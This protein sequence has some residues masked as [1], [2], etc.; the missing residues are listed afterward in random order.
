[1][2]QRPTV[3]PSASRL[4]DMHPAIQATL[5]CM[6]VQLEDELARYRRAQRRSP[7]R[8]QPTATAGTVAGV[9]GGAAALAIASTLPLPDAPATAAQPP[10]PGFVPPAPA[11]DS[12][13]YMESSEHL[14][15]SLAEDEA[16]LRQEP[17]PRM[18]DTLLTPLGI[19]SMIL[20]LLSSVTLGYVLTNPA[21]LSFMGTQAEAPED[22]SLMLEGSE[23]TTADSGTAA[24]G[25]TA[26]GNSSFSP[27]LSSQEFRSLTLDTLSTLPED[28]PIPETPVTATGT[29][30]QST[31]PGNTAAQPGSGASTLP[32]TPA[33]SSRSAAAPPARSAAAPAPR[34][35]PAPAPAPAPR[36]QAAAPAPRP[37]PAPAPAPAPSRSPAPVAAAPAAAS[38]SYFYVITDYTG[39]RALETAQSAMGD[40]YVRNFDMGAVIQF[41]AF[42]E[43]DRAESLIQDLQRQGI[44]ARIH[45]VERN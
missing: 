27:D 6:D 16:E 24:S 35:Q 37:Q 2:A 32:Q 33:T 45:R 20:L 4:L 26:S 25:N 21:S 41:G 43:A 5:N 23:S 31:A 39:D 10:T 40:A 17:A 7:A 9:A 44:S 30:S 42:S 14:L 18:L 36:P 38:S 3:E 1:M 34:P 8:S 22:E 15:R 28:Q 29:A 13:E 12:Y 11:E 19:G